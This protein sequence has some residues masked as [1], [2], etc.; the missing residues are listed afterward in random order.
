M[1]KVTVESLGRA[2]NNALEQKDQVTANLLKTVRN[3]ILKA[4]AE[5]E[6]ERI[7]NIITVKQTALKAE[8]N[9]YL[10]IEEENLLD[11]TLRQIEI[12]DGIMKE[13]E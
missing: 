5:N 2:I 8:G 6:P 9:M 13:F 11:N 7:Q 10:E 4:N 12:L 3:A 1:N